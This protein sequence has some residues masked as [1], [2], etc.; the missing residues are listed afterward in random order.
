M[1]NVD[2][3]VWSAK[4]PEKMDVNTAAV[5]GTI[6]S[7]G[8]HAQLEEGFSA[9]DVPVLSSKTFHK[10]HNIV[11]EAWEAT[12]LEE[13]QTAALEEARLAKGKAE[14][15]SDGIPTIKVVAG[16]CWS[17]CSYRTNYTALSR[18]VCT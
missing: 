2:M 6:S 14:V 18:V 1:C 9:L 11:C 17:K 15:D 5:S 3:P 8:R 13:M 7:G 12:A 16:G 10:Y 4:D